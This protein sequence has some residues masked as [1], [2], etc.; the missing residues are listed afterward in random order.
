MFFINGCSW[1]GSAEEYKAE[2]GR[3]TFRSTQESQGEIP[4]PAPQKV[5]GE[6]R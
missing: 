3:T 5:P 6:S 4:T 2:P 1:F